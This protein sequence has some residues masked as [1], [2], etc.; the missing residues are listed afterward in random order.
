M[1]GRSNLLHGMVHG[2]G[3]QYLYC[4]GIVGEIVEI[5]FSV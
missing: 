3:G 5:S 2:D 4:L 1:F